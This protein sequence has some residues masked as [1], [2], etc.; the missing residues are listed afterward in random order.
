M[1]IMTK[2]RRAH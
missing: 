1:K 2:T